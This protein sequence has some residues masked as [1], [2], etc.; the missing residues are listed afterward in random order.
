MEINEI[1]KLVQA[2]SEYGLTSFEL[3]EGN[4]RISLKREKE[5]VLANPLSGTADKMFVS[6]AP[7]CRREIKKPSRNRRISVQIRW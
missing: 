3:E 5:V 1:M 4:M 2:V 7:A 6:A